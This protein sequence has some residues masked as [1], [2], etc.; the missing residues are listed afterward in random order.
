MPVFKEEMGLSKNCVL[1]ELWEYSGSCWEDILSE[2]QY[3]REIPNYS[4]E[5]PAL[6]RPQLSELSQ[7]ATMEEGDSRF[8]ALCSFLGQE[9]VF[10][11]LLN[12]INEG[13]SIGL[14]G[15]N[16]AFDNSLR[17]L[18]QISYDDLY[19]HYLHFLEMVRS[20]ALNVEF[21]DKYLDALFYNFDFTRRDKRAYKW[22]Q[23]SEIYILPN[24]WFM[25]IIESIWVDDATY[26]E[27]WFFDNELS[28]KGS[29]D[30]YGVN[31][32]SAFIESDEYRKKRDNK[33]GEQPAGTSKP[34]TLDEKIEKAQESVE[35]AKSRY[36]AAI[37][38]LRDLLEMKKQQ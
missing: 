10:R 2:I 30:C 36:D 13:N 26:G 22:P 23:L 31:A 15:V 6:W 28:Y 17:E 12:S 4:Y 16:M 3:A 25:F 11:S 18:C 9:N 38:D 7:I 19:N 33:L 1:K 21:E 32:F 34:L 35:K 37:K 14:W 27:T 29:I 5:I 20:G 8:E 24:G